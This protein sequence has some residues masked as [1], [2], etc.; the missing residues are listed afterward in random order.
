MTC[1]PF[2]P[3]LQSLGPH[4]AS[5]RAQVGM[6]MPHLS[7]SPVQALTGTAARPL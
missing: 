3:A 5:P 2:P 1:W 7:S 4:W 6:A